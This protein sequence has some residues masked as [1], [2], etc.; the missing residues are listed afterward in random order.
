MSSADY[1]LNPGICL[2]GRCVKHGPRCSYG[3]C[4]NHC[5][6]QH[7]FGEDH[8]GRITTRG[9]LHTYPRDSTGL[10]SW[11]DVSGESDSGSWPEYGWGGGGGDEWSISSGSS[12]G[13]NSNPAG[14]LGEIEEV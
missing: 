3:F 4:A 13:S 9:L 1:S 2:H 12:R 7:A 5:L 8:K 10:V 6:E 14:S 11:E